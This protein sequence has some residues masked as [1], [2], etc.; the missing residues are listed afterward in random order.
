M[1]AIATDAYA[2]YVSRIGRKPAPMTAD[3]TAAVESASVWIAE[4]AKAVLGFVITRRD[5]DSILIETVAV[6]TAAQGRGIGLALM[7]QAESDA[8]AS[9]VAIIRLYT[10][11]AMTENLAY[12][13][14]HGYRETHRATEDGYRR[15]FFEKRLPD[16][17]K[18]GDPD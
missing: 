6:A 9:G 1:A 10:N 12:Y 2:K 16:D 7:N 5:R 18:P 4:T 11:V 8:R 17:P 13:S 14:R 15:V 3:Y